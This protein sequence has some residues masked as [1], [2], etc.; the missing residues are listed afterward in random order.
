M[1]SIPDFS[2]CHVTVVGDVMLDLY[3]WG[4][5][6]Q[7]SP[8]APV[9]ICR[10]RDITRVL[11]GAGNTARNLAGLKCA[12]SLLGV[13]GKDTAGQALAKLLQESGIDGSLFSSS[14][15]TTTTKSRIIGQGQQLLRL[16]EETIQSLSDDL[17]SKLIQQLQTTLTQTHAAIISDYGKGLFHTD[18][19]PKI[20]A[21][22]RKADRPIFIDPKGKAWDRYKGA[23][24]ITPNLAEF[25]QQFDAPL[26]STTDLDTRAKSIL[27]KL[28]LDYLLITMGAKGMVLYN[29]NRALVQIPSRAQEVADVSGAG[30]TV[31][32]TMAGAVA[33]GCTMI[34][35]AGLANAAASVVVTKLGTQAITN[36]EL[37][38]ALLKQEIHA[39]AK[40]ESRETAQKRI[41]AWQAEGKRVVFTNGCFDIL[42]MGHIKLLQ[43]AAKQGDKLIVAINSDDS[44]RRLKG[45]E[46]PVMSE[47]SRAGLMANIQWVDLVVIF[48]EDT[49][50]QLIELFKPDVLVKGGDYTPETVVGHDVV[51]HWGG[52]VV[53]IDLVDGVSTTKVIEKLNGKHT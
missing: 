36:G 34:D 23:T 20:I 24:C 35:A 46:R 3:Y 27:E 6:Q 53:L 14:D 37:Q 32:A 11:G 13:C 44:V 26:N 49:P 1:I 31:I 50:L 19:A 42:H 15:L 16:D 47:T 22:C 45:P 41:A 39:A 25:N 10:V 17:T 7:I 52:E 12:T 9:P 29:A 30:D 21:V 2:S 48:E 40:V 38:T 43:S 5:V 51:S 4:D 33:T 18:L 8:E 28:K